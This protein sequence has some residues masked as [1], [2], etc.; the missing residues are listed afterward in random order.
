MVRVF[1]GRD[2]FTPHGW[3]GHPRDY[4]QPAMEIYEGAKFQTFSRGT[5]ALPLVC[6]RPH[7]THSFGIFYGQNPMKFSFNVVLADLILVIL[8]TRTVRFLLR[9]LREP[10]FISELIGGII[11]GPSLLGQSKSF[12]HIVFPLYSNFVMRNVGVMGFMLF[13]FISGVKMDLGLLKRSGKKNFYI[14]LISIVVPLVIVTVVAIIT[15]KSMDKELARASSIGIIA[16][17][18]AITAFPIHYAVLQELNLLSSE[19]GNMALSIAL[20]SDTIGMNCLVIFEAMKQ[21]EVSGK[22]ALWYMISL[23]VLLA[24]TVTAV[25]RAMMWIIET[26]P[27]GEPVDQFYVVAILLGVFVMGFLTDMFGIAIANGSFLLGLVIPNGPPLGATLV[28][29]SETIIMEIIMPFSFAFIG[30]N[31]DFSAM[32][33]AGWSTL[34]PLFAMVISGYLSKLLSTLMAAYMVAMPLRDCL[35]LSL[36]LSLRGQ[37]ELIL[38]VHWVDKNIIKLPGFTMMVFLTMM[39]TGTL[40]PLI[41]IFYDPTKPYMVN[42]RR[43]VQHTPPDTELGILLCI[44]DKESVPSL[45]NLLEVSNPTVNNPLS[46]YAFHLVE[47]I[48]RAN[49][50]FID[51]EDQEQEDLCIRFPDS[52]TI[53][54]ALKLYQERRDECVRLH[55]FTATTA[56][57][58]M[59]QDVCKLALISKAAIIILPFEKERVGDIAITE[60]WGGG[61]HSLSTNVLANAPCSVGVLVDKAHRWHL[62]LSRSFQGAIHNFIVLFLGGADAREALA[63]ADRMAG[64]P[65]VS[66]TVIRFLS[67]NSEGD[68]EREKKLDDGVVTWF[69]VKNETNERV[70]YREVVVRNGEETVS[71]IQ[72]MTEENY[73]HLWIMGRKQGINP[74]LLEGLST[75]TEN[76]EELG[77]IGDY[78]SSTDFGAADSVLVVQQQI[79]RAQGATIATPSSSFLRRLLT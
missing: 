58:T 42:K 40:T 37:V 16:S 28:E 27:E 12:S 43:T 7:E 26:T 72:T 69:W 23:V 77:I 54:H 3:R 30:L 10:R 6:M 48:G 76:Q 15:R 35:A 41:S 67:S 56:K 44:Q 21:G 50:L 19:V 38:Y 49:P 9:P 1:P 71:A 32:T 33:E 36:V 73:Y 5:A 20:V 11:I 55:L 2:L 61:Q 34:G 78:V 39:L 13:L 51:H 57:R 64:N 68:D 29:K 59:Y 60:H 62:P 70:I 45:V 53:Q 22:D 25:R 4:H 74:R 65:N 79:L 52:E 18:L 24:F 63:Y 75:W 8:I 31:T 46:V 47:L 17:S 14:A 66:L